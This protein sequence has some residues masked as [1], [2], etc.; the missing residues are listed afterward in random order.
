MKWKRSEDGYRTTFDGRDALVT[1]RQTEAVKRYP[2]Y[3]WQVSAGDLIIARGK[4][5]TQR[6]ARTEARKVLE[7]R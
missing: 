7:G 2:F 6:L 3:L 4:C 1:W 5:S